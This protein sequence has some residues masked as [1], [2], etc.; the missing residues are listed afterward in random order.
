MTSGWACARERMG[1]PS[2]ASAAP[3][4]MNWRRFMEPPRCVVAAPVRNTHAMA[5]PRWGQRFRILLRTAAVQ[6]GRDAHRIG[7]LLQLDSRGSDQLSP[8]L[9][10][11]LDQRGE[12]SRRI[13]D[14]AR[15]EL[16]EASLHLRVLERS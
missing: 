15:A 13:A 8:A 4:V 10:L 5:M 16:L 2:P 6:R 3:D 7:V 14:E 1:R 12:F 9:A 11:R